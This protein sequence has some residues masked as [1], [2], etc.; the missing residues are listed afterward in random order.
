MCS[1]RLI[2]AQ[3]ATLTPAHITALDSVTQNLFPGVNAGDVG[4]QRQIGVNLNPG[5]LILDYVL[6]VAP[7]VSN[8]CVP[9][10]VILEIQG[11][12]ETSNTGT[13]T[14]YVNDWTHQSTPNN[15]FLSQQLSTQ[16]LR[17]HL[18][19]QKVNV[20]GIIPN[21][22]W[23]RQL[24]QILKKALLS[25]QFSGAFALVTGDVLHAYIRRSIPAG[26]P[27]FPG[28]E[29]A[30]IGMSEVLSTSSGAIP[31]THVSSTLFMTFADF[32]A[33]LQNLTLPPGLPDP[34]R[35]NYTTLSNR[36]FYV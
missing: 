36:N 2:P 34:F 11:G 28:W 21:N 29:V 4:F 17:R 14:R 10:R 20:P 8:P 3:A 7:R 33:A 22:V 27:Y 18:G 15:S 24:E 5:R 30:L 32:V 31:I 26:G 19:I 6:Q 35:G 1:N 25:L 23:K 16:Y 12:G 9:S 13:I